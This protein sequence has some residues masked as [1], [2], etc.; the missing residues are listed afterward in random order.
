MAMKLPHTAIQPI[1]PFF[2][3]ALTPGWSPTENTRGIMAGPGALGE[4]INLRIRVLDRDGDPVTN[5]MIE[6]WQAD[7]AGKYNHPADTQ[8]KIPDPAFNG[9]GRVSS[10]NQGLCVFETV[11]PGPV[12]SQAP[13]I[14]LTAF[15]PGLL[16]SVSTR[17]YFDGD[18]ANA[19]DYILGLVPEDRRTTLLARPGLEPAD[20]NFDL[21]L[22]GPCETVFF[23]I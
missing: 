3:F 16:R 4:R 18:P 17:I 9:F 14:S 23:D 10:D 22:S 21:R 20:W 7:A 19:S 5:A 1:G 11:K 6:L 8:T 15:A 13:H 12:Q 2:H